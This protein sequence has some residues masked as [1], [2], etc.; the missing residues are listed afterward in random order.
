MTGSFER[1]FAMLSAVVIGGGFVAIVL[2]LALFAFSVAVTNLMH[3]ESDAIVDVHSVL[4]DADSPSDALAAGRRLTEHFF[5]PQLRI[6][7]FDGR[8]RVEISRAGVAATS[9]YAIVT[10]PRNDLPNGFAPRTPIAR[11]TLA[12]ATLFGL[13]PQHVEIG[14]LLVVVRVDVSALAATVERGLPVFGAALVLAVILGVAFGR[15]LVHEALRPLRD[16]TAALERFAAGDFTPGAVS[17]RRVEDLSRL[18][19]AYNGAVEQ[20]HHAFA[21][22]DRAHQT[23]RQFMTDAGHQ[24]RT[25]LTVVRGFIGILRR[26]WPDTADREHILG[27]MNRQ[28]VVMGSLI[29]KLILLEQWDQSAFPADAEPIDLSRL[30]EDVVVPIAESFP[31]RD[32]RLRLAAGA[33][34]RIDPSD[35]AHALTNLLDNALKY[36]PDGPIDVT[37][38]ADGDCIRLAVVDHGPGMSAAEAEHA[39]DRFFRGARNRDVAGSGLGLAIARRAVERARGTLSLATVPGQGT[40]FTIELPRAA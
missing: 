35:C 40:C 25:P 36:A 22:R 21:E 16:V 3:D 18:A 12:L 2:A 31:A 11:A 32:V 5:R 27:A 29:E 17:G 9:P 24:L 19:V 33:L 28:C 38:V 8:Q 10:R 26:G 14:P 7:V 4:R 34:A 20:V 37:L 30:V 6:F 13:Q 23:M 1:R 15:V 39:F